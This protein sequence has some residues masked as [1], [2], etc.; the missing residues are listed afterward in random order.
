MRMLISIALL[1]FFAF[2]SAYLAKQKG[3]DPVG[4]FMI[5]ILLGIFSP[6]LLLILKPLN[7]GSVDETEIDENIKLSPP[8][9]EEIPALKYS[10]KEWFYLDATRQQQ[11]PVY[12]KTLKSLLDE[13]KISE[14]TYVWSEG[15]S[16]W[17]RIRELPGFIE[18]L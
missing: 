4:W 9:N 1:L 14:S 8:I 6:V 11:G 5:G 18:S 13:N 16:K 3:R 12:H 7:K 2:L 17:I 15:M 10:S